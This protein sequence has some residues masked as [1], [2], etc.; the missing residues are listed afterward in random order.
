MVTM[1]DNHI[2]CLVSIAK[3]LTEAAE[4]A[5]ALEKS[6]FWYSL[7]NL[8]AFPL[9]SETFALEKF[10][11]MDSAREFRRAGNVPEYLE[12]LVRVSRLATIILTDL[13]KVVGQ[14]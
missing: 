2:A 3:A 14:H 9:R 1:S 6:G 8:F 10:D 13:G 4:P 12:E 7:S 5:L 11:R